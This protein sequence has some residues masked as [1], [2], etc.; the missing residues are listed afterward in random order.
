M[1]KFAALWNLKVDGLSW[2]FSFGATI[3]VFVQ[4][5]FQSLT[6]SA[7]ITSVVAHSM[8]QTTVKLQKFFCNS[9][10]GLAFSNFIG[11]PHKLYPKWHKVKNISA[12]IL[13]LPAKILQGL[14]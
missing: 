13:S 1:S 10:I 12:T 11:C 9:N 6:V 4:I 2:L 5:V 3:S 14:Y 7:E 8:H